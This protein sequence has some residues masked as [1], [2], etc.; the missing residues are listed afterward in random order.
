MILLRYRDP[1]GLHHL[2]VTVVEVRGQTDINSS[3]CAKEQPR[4]K[5]KTIIGAVAQTGKVLCKYYA[6]AR[7]RL[8]SR[9][10]AACRPISFPTRTLV[11][12]LAEALAKIWV[13]GIRAARDGR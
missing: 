11:S 13:F 6:R 9:F 2:M 7:S 3:V 5:T 4:L 1:A 12:R 8:R 10:R